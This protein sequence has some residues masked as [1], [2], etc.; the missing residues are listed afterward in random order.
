MTNTNRLA[1]LGA[2][3]AAAFM[4]FAGPAFADDAKIDTGDT[5]WMLTSTAIV[6][7]MTIPGVALFYAGMVRKKNVLATLMQS[8]AITALISVLWMVVGYSLA[9]GEGGAFIGDFSRVF[10]SGMTW[11]K[12]FT[13]GTG[14]GAVAFTIPEV[15]FVMFQMTFAII[16][17]AL[18]CGA[19]ADRFK[20]SALL[21]F[22]GLWSILV[23]APVAHWVWHPNGWL[24]G[25]GALDFAGGTVVHINAGIAGLVAAIVIGKRKGYGTENFSPFNLVLAVIG[26]SLLWVGW[27]GFNAGSAAAAS[28]RAGMAML[29][30]QVATG[31]AAMA[32]MF[33]EW[34]TRGKPSVL[35]VISG[36][37]AGLVAITPAAGFVTPGGS[38][39][40]GVVAGVICF[41]ASTSLKKALGYDDSLDVFGVHGVGGIVG[42]LLTGVLAA[43]ALSATEA[44]PEGLTGL[45]EGNPGQ[46][47]IQVYATAATIIY[48]GVASLILLKIVDAIV[49]LRVSEE[50]ER[51]GLDLSLHGESVQ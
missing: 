50:A 4:G 47:M 15:V 28:G 8:F 21:W 17:P 40:I 11:D 1:T 49:G 18:I 48:S 10:L 20:F 33:A 6:L 46:L 7:M 43:G 45:L 14:D 3:A 27:F 35:G 37:V 32:W 16:T 42:A 38:L 24:F 36:A 22:I 23:Y 51:D 2:L 39:V 9:F 34:A 44:L 25:L 30:T 19:F 5:A 13:L 29:A 26:A 41:W 12:P 31:A